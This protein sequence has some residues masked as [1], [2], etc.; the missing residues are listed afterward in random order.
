[1]QCHTLV[2]G[3]KTRKRAYP[4]RKAAKIAL[5]KAAERHGFNAD[6]YEVYR[7]GECRLYHYGR[8]RKQKKARELRHAQT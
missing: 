4:S 1:M 8:K 5:R 2:S 6:D 7:C 3:R